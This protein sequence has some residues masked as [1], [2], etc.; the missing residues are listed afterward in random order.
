MKSLR[1]RSGSRSGS[2]LYV[3]VVLETIVDRFANRFDCCLL[4]SLRLLGL[5]GRSVPRTLGVT[6][7][8]FQQQLIIDVL[9]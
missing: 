4:V 2:N 8:D 3:G 5:I 9:A 6:A 1:E 7:R